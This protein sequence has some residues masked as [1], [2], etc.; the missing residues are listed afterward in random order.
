MVIKYCV[1]SFIDIKVQDYEMPEKV[2]KFLRKFADMFEKPEV[3]TLA[4]TMSTTY[5][6]YPYCQKTEIENLIK[7]MLTEGI[8]RPNSPFASPVLLVKKK[9]GSWRFCV[10]YRQLNSLSITDKFSIPI[11]DELVDELNGA[12]YFTKIDLRSGYFQIRVDERDILKLV[13][14]LTQDRTSSW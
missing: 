1:E 7:E 10:D 5:T 12:C 11:I 8:N 6:W 13:S 3:L 9:N 4:E 2:D 14:E